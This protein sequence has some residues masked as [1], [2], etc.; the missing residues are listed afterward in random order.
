MKTCD[1]CK[2]QINTIREY[3]PL[4]HQILSGENDPDHVE[5]FLQKDGPRV[6]LS[7]KAQRIVLFVFLFAISVLAVINIIDDSGLFWSLIPIGAIVYLWF[8]L[9][10][11]VFSQ[12][13]SVVRITFSSIL[14][15]LLLIFLN[16]VI[17]DTMLWSVD[18]TLPAIIMVNNFIILLI[19]LIRSKAFHYNAFP[20]FLLVLLSLVPLLLYF[21]GIAQNPRI[22]VV[23]FAHGILILL[24][25]IVFYPKVLKEILKKIFHI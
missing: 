10:L 1:K 12:L 9:K 21:I 8:I 3:C 7:P 19:M 24:F 2:I 18:Y 11:N 25:M 23:T 17:D 20:L 22:A 16:I 14:I 6:P 15:S 5:M 13:G 4:C